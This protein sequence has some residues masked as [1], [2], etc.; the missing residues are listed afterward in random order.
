[1]DHHDHTDRKTKNHN[2]K[3]HKPVRHSR[4]DGTRFS[5]YLDASSMLHGPRNL[6]EMIFIFYRIISSCLVAE[7]SVEQEFECKC[8]ELQIMLKQQWFPNCFD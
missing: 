8:S 2:A 7:K 5:S 1:M 3:H 6:F 4:I